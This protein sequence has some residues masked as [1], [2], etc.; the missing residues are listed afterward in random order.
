ML[1]LRHPMLLGAAALL[2]S[3]N[4]LAA[5]AGRTISADAP[6]LLELGQRFQ[7]GG[8][9]E[10]A[11]K[12]YAALEEDPN[13]DV[14]AEARF[15]LARLAM[16]RKDWRSAALLL[17]RVLDERPEAAPVRL[18][19]AQVL[20]E[21]GDENAA[22]REL[23]AAQAI[24]LPLDVARMVD[25]FSEAL[26]ARRP[27]GASLKLAIAPDS[28]INNA[29]A[30]DTL[31]TVIGDFEIDGDS[32]QRS[33]VGTTIQGS[34]YLR[35]SIGP[36]I[37]LLAR[38]FASGDV[39]RDKEFNRFG[40]EFAAG[41]ELSFGYAR[42]NLE[43]AVGRRWL[44]SQPFEDRI[45]IEAN[46]SV[47]LGRQTVARGRLTAARVDNR[48]NELQDGNI[49]GGEIG[50]ER[51]IDART[52]L[53]FTLFGERAALGDAGYS[54]KAWRAQLVA[55]R[56]IGRSTIHGTAAY[57]Q[58]KADE[59][60]ALFPERREDKGWSLSLGATLRQFEFAG[61]APL[62]RFTIERNDSNIAFYEFSRRR[63]EFG[64]VRAF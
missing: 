24:G 21:I 7:A 34:A 42:L 17:R 55:W 22:L 8:Q 13:A 11:T 5:S 26:R 50:V 10:Q 54:T 47:P 48:L 30:N 4:A 43:A 15:R 63:A 49:L 9:S 35:H 23:R 61:F 41:P 57:G 58:L 39:Y 53:S 14:R 51:A 31:G 62:V 40:L 6:A 19:L 28:N 52:G 18:T 60:L 64:A 46:G 1:A 29:T 16:D 36:N 44:G 59:R 37:S 56:E 45:R 27:F 12:V 25:R 2:V 33:G 32:K 3:S 20:T 38:T